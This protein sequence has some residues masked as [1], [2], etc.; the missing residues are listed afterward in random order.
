[1]KR[2]TLRTIEIER[3]REG[4]T[5]RGRDRERSVGERLYVSVREDS[6]YLYVTELGIHQHN[7]VYLCNL[8]AKVKKS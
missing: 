8:K 2:E 6:S 4:E 7:S 3:E 5:W 1:M